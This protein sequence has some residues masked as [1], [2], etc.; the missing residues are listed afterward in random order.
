MTARSVCFTIFGDWNREVLESPEVKC[1]VVQLEKAPDTGREHYQGFLML[2][3]PQRFCAVKRILNCESAH[4]E[5]AKGTPV[6]AWEYCCKED[7]RVDGPW[8]Y[9]EKPKGSGHR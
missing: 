1:A 4:V 8:I 5:K 6:Q 7:T 2:N 9:G 3:K